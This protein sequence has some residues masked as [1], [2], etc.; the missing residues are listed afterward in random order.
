MT[1]ELKLLFLEDNPTDADLIQ[2][3]LRRAG[4]SFEAVLASDE[5]EFHEALDDNGFDAVLADNALPQYS[6]ME[7]LKLIRATNPHVAFILVTGTVSEE[8][9]VK[10]IQQ[11]ADDYILKTNLTRLPAAIKNAIEKKQHQR[12]KESAERETTKEKEFSSSIINSLPGI[13]YLC[14]RDGK[15]L[16]WNKNF[17]R[18]AGYSSSEISKMT[19]EYFISGESKDHVQRFMNKS[20]A[21]G[22]GETEVL[23]IT[24]EA[25]RIPYFF[26]SIATSFEQ[27]ECLICVGLDISVSKQGEEE[28]KQAYEQLRLLSAHLHNIKEEEQ[29]RIARE[30]HDE[31]G[32]QITGLKMD[33]AW[34]KKNL[35]NTSPEVNHKLG[36]MTSLMDETVS[37]IR[38]IATELRPSI[39]DD[40]GLMA[41]LDWQSIEFEKRFSIPVRFSSSHQ[42][43]DIDPSL[44]IAIFRIYQESLTNIARHSEEKLV[45]CN[46]MQLPHQLIL[47]I[48]DNGKGFNSKNGKA[49]KTLGLLG[50]KER[51]AMIGGDMTIESVPGNGTTVTLRLGLKK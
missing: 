13:F 11:G 44:G 29:R 41:A 6:S 14:D 51:A 26:T 31:L 30:I 39:L 28:L 5:K 10:I 36:L 1:K 27:K 8:F 4:I 48:T 21:I 22:H 49:K 37:T 3:T 46:L 15:L 20:F 40:M 9:A 47:T 2:L 23:F 17:E 34:L 43:I 50:M 35:A 38:K 7:A 18:I 45:V 16:R 12:Q 25:K 19:A 33:V 32:Q 42:T 24:R